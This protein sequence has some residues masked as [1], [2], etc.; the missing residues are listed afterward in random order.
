MDERKFGQNQKDEA[1]NKMSIVHIVGK[2][3]TARYLK[4]DDYPDDI[5][6]AVNHAAIFMDKIDYLFANDVEGLEGIPDEIFSRVNTFVIPLHPHLDGLPKEDVTNEYVIKKY[7]LDRFNPNYIIYNLHTWKNPN[8]D[9][10]TPEGASSTSGMAIGYFLKYKNI[11][12]FETYGIGNKEGYNPEVYRYIS[13]E[14]Y[15]FEK[16]WKRKRIEN[17]RHSIFKIVKKYNA[18]INFN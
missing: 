4:H 18:T 17:L 16:N 14:N 15:K 3:S 12:H 10:V 7:D 5:F 9:L 2:G 8:P 13:K 11:K 1:A 6:V